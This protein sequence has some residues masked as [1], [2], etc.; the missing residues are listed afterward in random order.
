VASSSASAQVAVVATWNDL[1]EGTWIGRNCD[2]CAGGEWLDPLT[3]AK[4][5]RVSQCSN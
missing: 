3:F 5:I 2:H 4:E 1:G